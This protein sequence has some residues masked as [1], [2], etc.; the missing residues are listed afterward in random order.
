MWN[1]KYI[2]FS[3]LFI[4]FSIC[5]A[6]VVTDSLLLRKT[7]SL[8]DSAVKYLY[9]DVE[10]SIFFS[11]KAKEFSLLNKDTTNIIGCSNLTGNAYH[12]SG[13]YAEAYSI[14][15][16][17][18]KIAIESKNKH[19]K[20]MSI[21]NL[22][23]L[24]SDQNNY[25]EAKKYNYEGIH[26]AIQNKDSVNL[27]S[28]YNNLAIVF[29]NN[30][31]TDSAII[32][33]NKS[34]E[35]RKK[36]KK[37]KQV[38]ICLSNIGTIYFEKKDFE[39]SIEFQLEALKYDSESKNNFT[40]SN[41]AQAYLNLGNFKLAFEYAN[42]ALPLAEKNHDIRILDDLYILLFDYEINN[43]DYKKAIHYA[44][45]AFKINEELSKEESQR[46]INETEAKYQTEKNELE[47][48]NLQNQKKLQDAELRKQAIL[49][50]SFGLGFI[51][52]LAFASVLFKSYKLKSKA[53]KEIALQK[54]LLEYKQKEIL[55]SIHYAQRIQQSIQP[56]KEK[57]LEWFPESFIF[58][59]P[60]DIVSGD[61]F[62]FT[63]VN[64][65]IYVV[66][67]DCTG[68]G[69]PG[70]LMSMIGMNSLHQIIV[71]NEIT[72]T[73]QILNTLHIKVKMAMNADVSAARASNDGMDLALIRFDVRNKSIQ[74]SGAS[75]PLFYFKNK[76]LYQLKGDRYSIGGV[77]NE[78]T[79]Y[80][81]FELSA[82]E[83]DTV[84]LF[85]DGYADQMGGRKQGGKK[86]KISGLKQILES[87]QDKTMREQE[88]VISTEYNKW[89]GELEQIDDVCVIGIR[90]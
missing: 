39:K 54:S 63:K 62:W 45:K 42:K 58:F 47:I 11:K 1:K 21:V 55:D 83:F 65:F 90:V 29:Q 48:K 86:L 43:K 8:F 27:G 80:Q 53:N 69:V 34:I 15:S 17:A 89:K 26:L 10:K 30:N 61:F 14:Y 78:E 81:L 35:V 66:A 60:K 73:H 18:Y 38:A 16:Q 72:E 23:I 59:Q 44:Q 70:A 7:N 24:F 68:H 5:K 36:I 12:I 50:Y 52:I 56:K 6:S 71:E 76:E 84:Y 75:R 13:K 40:F 37:F 19:G 20:L 2:L 3:Y 51:L 77:K 85:S 25:K 88:I 49:K 28:L 57:L 46:I 32:Y 41:I 74:F 22:G 79:S 67:A 31:E 64:H 82:G 87:I 33:Y 9:E 4:F